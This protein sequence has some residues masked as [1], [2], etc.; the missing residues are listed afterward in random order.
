MIDGDDND[1]VIINNV[2]ISS[3][4]IRIKLILVY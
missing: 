4:F 3:L 1:N 2:L